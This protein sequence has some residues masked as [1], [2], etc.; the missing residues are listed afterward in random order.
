MIRSSVY[1]HW[2]RFDRITVRRSYR[3]H[4]LEWCG[5][6]VDAT[7]QGFR[8]GLKGL[9]LR[10]RGGGLLRR[11][12]HGHLEHGQWKKSTRGPRANISSP[13]LHVTHWT[14]YLER[15]DGVG[16]RPRVCAVRRLV[17]RRRRGVRFGGR[18]HHRNLNSRE[19]ILKANL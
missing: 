4:G 11:Q 15:V 2:T 1:F 19:S 7:V 16:L 12:G 14:K 5:V 18:G 8:D 9:G 13:R 10:R 6:D 3:L 17:E